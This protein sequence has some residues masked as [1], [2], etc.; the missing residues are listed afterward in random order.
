[1]NQETLDRLRKLSQQYAFDSIQM[2]EAI[3]RQ[4]GLS[5]TDHKYL[6]FIIQKGQMTAGEL[7]T[8]TGL[9]TGAVTGLID[10]F[11]QKDLVKRRFGGDRRKVIVEPN[12]EK[13]M[14]VFEPLYREFRS[15]SEQVM[16]S[17]SEQELAVIEAYF[18]KA[19]EVM[20]ETTSQLNAKQS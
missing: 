5:G 6:G 12:T 15:K 13:I 20:N 9:T 2:H 7:S 11:E 3:G 19:I 4:A 10:R 8:L 16:A 14:A 18:L 17:F 1:M